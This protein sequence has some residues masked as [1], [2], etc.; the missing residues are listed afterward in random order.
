M[1][2]VNI[3]FII[4]S[5][6]CAGGLF[7]YGREARRLGRLLASGTVAEAAVLKKEKIDSWTARATQ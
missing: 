4:L 6:F 5:V 7:A 1:E 3:G 2:H